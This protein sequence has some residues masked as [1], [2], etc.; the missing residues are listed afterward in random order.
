MKSNMNSDSNDLFQDGRVLT[1]VQLSH[2][3]FNP[4]QLKPHSNPIR[5]IQ[6]HSPQPSFNSIPLQLS[7]HL[8][9]LAG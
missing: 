3:E 8:T 7:L 9:Q 4:I 6:P 5:A 2:I 1:L